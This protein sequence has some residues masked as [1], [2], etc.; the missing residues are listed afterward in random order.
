MKPIRQLLLASLLSVVMA[1][2][3]HAQ[4]SVP[5]LLNYQGYLEE[6]G[7]PVA[8]GG[9]TNRKVYFRFWNHA[10]NS[11]A[12]NLLYSE[13]QTVTI[14]SGDF[15]V[16]LGQGTPIATDTALHTNI[17][18]AFGGAEVFLGITVDNG[19]GNLN[20]DS[21]VSPRQ[22]LVSTAYAFRSKVASTV[23]AG[24]ISNVMLAAG[25]VQA[26]NL[27]AG[28]VTSAALANGAVTGAK[29]ASATI[30]AAHL[31][32]NSVTA[33]AIGP[34]EVG[35]SE[36]ADGSVYTGDLADGAV[37]TV[38]ISA[39]AVGS[40]Q[41]GDGQVALVDLV[42]AVQQSLCPPGTIVAYGGANAPAGWLLCNGTSV[43]R[44]GTYAA[45]FSVI[46]TS[47]GTANVNSFNVPDF[48]GRFLRGRDDSSF[49][50]PDRTTRT[51]MSAG[52][53][54]GDAVGSVQLDAFRSHTHAYAVSWDR[55]GHPNGSGDTS[56]GPNANQQY[57]RGNRDLVRNSPT[58]FEGG[59]ETRP[60]NAYVNYIIKF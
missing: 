40:L 53:A 6:G 10:S 14:N 20:N 17:A 18:D 26:A 46:G 42:A 25:A 15:S 36:I 19:D 7:T 50:D 2:Q 8:A 16:L 13:E 28:A 11:G 45:L 59:N 1:G 29:I 24:A 39:G 49:R 12:P 33:A 21:E 5:S 55:I 9:T 44:T 38:K 51:A 37:T 4:A 23:D 52:G 3:A 31:A 43:P 60:V 35:T 41:I 27:D 57:W 34:G 47:F 56:T 22:R 54:A 30:T 58:S 48:R 32:A